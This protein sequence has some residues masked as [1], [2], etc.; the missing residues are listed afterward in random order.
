MLFCILFATYA[1]QS[2]I[3]STIEDI[4]VKN[5]YPNYV[6][7]DCDWFNK[8]AE[9]YSINQIIFL[10]DYEIDSTIG[11]EYCYLIEYIDSISVISLMA[12]FDAEPKVELTEP[13]YYCLPHLTDPLVGNQWA[14]NNIGMHDVWDDENLSYYGNNIKVGVVDSGIDI[15]LAYN[16][17]IQ[18]HEDLS[19]NIYND[20]QGNHGYNAYAYVTLDSSNIL[21]VQDKIGHGTHVAGIIG[22]R[23]YND[24]GIAGI[25][26][27]NDF[28]N[29]EGCSLYSIKIGDYYQNATRWRLSAVLNGIYHAYV[30]DGVRIFNCSIGV[31]GDEGIYTPGHLARL[32]ARISSPAVTN[33]PGLFICSAGN[34][35]CETTQYPAQSEWAISVAATDLFD[36][37][38]NYSSY[39]PTVDICAPGGTGLVGST[40][41]ILSTMPQDTLFYNYTH[42]PWMSNYYEFAQGTSMAAPMVTGAVVLVKEAFPNLRMQEIKDRIIGTADNISLEE[43]R[44]ELI[45]KLG[46]GRL[47]V[48]KALTTENEHPTMRLNAVQITDSYGIGGN[49]VICG[50]PNVEMDIQLKNW[51]VENTNGFSGILT[52]DDPDIEII[53]GEANWDIISQNGTAFS[54]HTLSFED[55]S[56]IPR[57]ILFKLTVEY[58][59]IVEDLYFKVH[60]Q[61]NYNVYKITI[62]NRKPT[63]E[64][65]IGDMD[66]DDIEEIAL[67]TKDSLNCYY[68]N[69]IAQGSISEYQIQ[70]ISTVKPAFADINYDGIKELV[71]I[72][73]AGN[74][75]ILN[76]YLQIIHSTNVFSNYQVQSFVVEDLNDDGLFDITMLL[77]FTVN[78][79]VS[80]KIRSLVM[81]ENFSY[82]VYDYYVPTGYTVLSK[83]LAVG[84]VDLAPQYEVLFVQSHI[85][86]NSYILDMVKLTIPINSKCSGFA[87]ESGK[88]D[89]IPIGIDTITHLGVTDMILSK[90][91]PMDQIAHQIEK[92]SYIYFGRGYTRTFGIPYNDNQV[93]EFTVY[94]IDFWEEEP[95]I[96]WDHDYND[97]NQYAYHYQSMQA[98]NIIAGDFI[99]NRPGIEIITAATDEV[100]DSETGEFIQFTIDKYLWGFHLFSKYQPAVIIDYD[101]D[102]L[103]ELFL[104]RGSTL[105]C[106]D[107][108]KVEDYLYHC[109]LPDSI[110]SL[111]SGKARNPLYRD[112]YALGYQLLNN[113]TN[114]YYIPLTSSSN[115]IPYEWRQFNNNDRKTCEFYQPI[116]AKITNE[117]TVWNN[118]VIERDETKIDTNA[119]L[120]LDTGITIRMSNGSLISNYSSFELEGIADTLMI[121]LKGMCHKDILSYWEGIVSFN[122]STLISQYAYIKNADTGMSLF[123]TGHYII[124]NSKFNANFCS[125]SGYNTNIDMGHD[126]IYN[127]EYGVSSFHFSKANM[128]FS[129]SYFQGNN[130]LLDNTYG[131]YNTESEFYL[132]EGHNDL[133]NILYNIYAGEGCIGVKARY[134]WWGCDNERG[135][136]EKFFQPDLICYDNWDHQPNMG[137][138]RSKSLCDY[139]LAEGYR[140]EGNWSLAIPYYYSVYSDSIQSVEDNLCIKGLFLCYK[141]LNQLGSFITWVNSEL[142]TGVTPSMAKQLKNSLALA[143]R[144]TGNYQSAIDYYESILDNNPSYNDSCFAVIDLGF[145]WLESSTTVK[146]K[147]TMYIPKSM[148]DHITNTNKLLRS[149]LLNE[150]ITNET[151]IPIIPILY[152]NYPNPFNLTTMFHFY[153]PTKSKVELTIYN[154]K[155]QKVKTLVSS[156]L[157]KGNH[158]LVWDSK[159]NNG[160]S[161]GSGVYFY[162]LNTPRKNIVKKCL[163]MK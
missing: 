18:I 126:A 83:N 20:G 64:L 36:K 113:E 124:T 98:L 49:V 51:W 145:T 149:I 119:S 115:E 135:I 76:K 37:M 90:P 35:G 27:G 142:S 88:V 103:K 100:L 39:H 127:S 85:S 151:Q 81:Q 143:N 136:R 28:E 9:D 23:Y 162:K 44:I 75:Y 137:N 50:D 65:I 154:I 4:Q 67:T 32:M 54:N 111:I 21:N 96:Q 42:Y 123:D 84:N 107:S 106:Y 79:N 10:C 109:N 82:E 87:V 148:P 26:G 38:A 61:V 48:Y 155:G 66:R 68:V 53:H 43:P 5:F 150:P 134:N 30:N 13:D 133:D 12:K 101:E 93:G 70:A 153:L 104:Y 125:I 52:T 34:S 15:G 14:L 116:P 121:E 152:Q 45:G 122:E 108:Q 73:N 102:N 91:H 63:S 17:P 58:D 86:N 158:S 95:E 132:E 138:G 160:K 71:V 130:V 89:V 7:T 161:V 60:R 24:L 129:T 74:L 94:C 19:D 78:N 157:D 55:H 110:R 31:T 11:K 159:D 114:L 139:Q 156:S 117:L 97:D 8:L 120:I 92:K 22:A 141:N 6:E 105:K 131:M 69:L 29:R 112:V 33:D 57:D 59:N 2:L 99:P 25:A 118:S 144:A 56:S 163:L 47:N 128:G 1:P 3:F 72:D 40:T 46:A 16:P 80:W 62:Q 140:L 147:Y 146:G 41:G 77:K